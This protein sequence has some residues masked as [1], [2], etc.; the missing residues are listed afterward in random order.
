MRCDPT[1]ERS[2]TVFFGETIMKFVAFV[3]VLIALFGLLVYT[4]PTLDDYEDF[5]RY[6]LIG[7]AETARGPTPPSS[8]SVLLSEQTQRRDY[9]IL[10]LY[11]TQIEG[12]TLRVFGLLRNFFI[13]EAPDYFRAARRG[14]SA[15]SV[16]ELQQNMSEEIAR[17]D[18]ET[19]RQAEADLQAEL[20]QEMQARA[21]EAA[22]WRPPNPAD[23]YDPQVVATVSRYSGLIKQRVENSWQIPAGSRSDLACTLRISLADDGRVVDVQ[24]FQSS[25]DAVFD[26]TA[27]K[28]VQTAS[29]LPVPADPVA[30]ARFQAFKFVFR[31]GG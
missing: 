2:S 31:P 30:R 10:S 28:A 18:E 20:A 21:E 3:L 8:V 7:E 6:S 5:L 11:R 9:L 22:K 24:I 15:G 14:E 23:V 19:R 27:V 25:G 4:N 12:K 13:L 26:A 29:P 16:G 17:R 1:D